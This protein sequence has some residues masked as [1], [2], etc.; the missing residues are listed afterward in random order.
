ML[1]KSAIVGGLSVL[2]ACA[3]DCR[4]GVTAAEW[5]GGS[6][7]WPTST[8]PDKQKPFAKS[9]QLAS[10]NRVLSIAPQIQ[11]GPVWCWA[12]VSGMIFDWYD[13]P[14]LSPVGVWQCGIV[15][16][17]AA[18]AGNA[19]CVYD[20]KRCSVP[21]GSAQNLKKVLQTYPI[22]AKSK[23]RIAADIL[24]RP[25]RQ[26]E[27]VDMIDAER[28][29]IA[30]IN[31]GAPGQHFGASEHVALIVGY[32]QNGDFLVVNDP[33]PFSSQGMR[34]YE[35]ANG[36]L[37]KTGQYLISYSDFVS[38]IDWQETITVD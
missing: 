20:C 8:A 32:H 15:G 7:G 4:D 16:S 33:Y 27:V 22:F 30:G 12:A 25:L 37:R 13:V 29:V 9:P 6:T 28:P 24:N 23:T 19:E 26:Q 11:L 14:N 38:R 34:P 31:P 21:A 17:V 1:S 36:T 5:P 2:L 35:S 3:V 10:S 18:M